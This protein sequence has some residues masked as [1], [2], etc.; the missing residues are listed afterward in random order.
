MLN[1]W[2]T[3]RTYPSVAANIAAISPADRPCHE[4]STI[5][6]RRSRTRSRADLVILTSRWASSGSNDRANTSG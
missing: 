1:A 5:P 6:D 4:A 3:S 2:I